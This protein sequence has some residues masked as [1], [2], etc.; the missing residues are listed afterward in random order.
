MK[1]KKGTLRNWFIKIL[2][3]AI[4]FAM[5]LSAFIVVFR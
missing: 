3:I 1:I 4:V 5:I 2:V